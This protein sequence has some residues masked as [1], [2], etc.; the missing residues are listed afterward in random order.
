MLDRS[1]DLMKD[2]DPSKNTTKSRKKKK[3]PS[4]NSLICVNRREIL[5]YLTRPW[6]GSGRY[7]NVGDEGVGVPSEME[8]KKLG[9]G[10]GT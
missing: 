10:K 9:R 1:I 3:K 4:K 2:N 6:I 5:A 8:L 7:A